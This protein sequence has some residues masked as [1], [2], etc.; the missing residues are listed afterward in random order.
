MTGQH[1]APAVVDGKGNTVFGS[2]HMRKVETQDEQRS[3][4]YWAMPE[5]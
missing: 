1:R 4:N 2:Q 3:G 5:A